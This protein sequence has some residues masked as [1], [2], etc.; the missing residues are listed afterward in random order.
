MNYLQILTDVATENPEAVEEVVEE[1]F[2]LFETLNDNPGVTAAIGCL[3]L[4]VVGLGIYW[5]SRGKKKR[6]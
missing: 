4:L 3:V 6:R 1:T 2:N 5:F